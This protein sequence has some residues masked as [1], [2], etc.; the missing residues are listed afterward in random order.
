MTAIFANRQRTSA[1]SGILKCEAVYRFALAL[2]TRGTEY[3]QDVPAAAES[4][5]LDRMIRDIPGQRSGI[6][7]QYFWMLAGSDDFIKPDRMILRFLNEALGRM[8]SPAEAQTL[9]LN[10]TERLRQ[11][12]PEITPR[13]LD[14][15]IWKHQREQHVNIP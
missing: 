14:H 11:L 3:F 13:L 8:V 10:A 6:S 5:S 15:E 9:L 1:R 12:H 4:R 7:L 2:R